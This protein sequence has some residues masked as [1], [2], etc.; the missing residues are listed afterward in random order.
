MVNE[1]EDYLDGKL[2]SYEIVMERLLK[3]IRSGRERLNA[4]SLPNQ[5][6]AP[7]PGTEEFLG[8][9]ENPPPPA[10]YDEVPSFDEASFFD[11]DAN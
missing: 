10:P 11:Q 3:T 7:H 1:H 5:S 4:Q 2:G 6:M 9:S 8:T